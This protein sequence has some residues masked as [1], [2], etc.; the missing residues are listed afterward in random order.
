MT[1]GNPVNLL[2]MPTSACDGDEQF[3]TL[4]LDGVNPSLVSK[5]EEGA[6]LSCMYTLLTVIPA[7]QYVY[8]PRGHA[9]PHDIP[10][11]GEQPG[12]GEGPGAGPVAGTEKEDE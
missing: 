5:L 2:H 8:P 7:G 1:V 9:V 11:P 3:F 12:N 4:G 6:Q 10:T